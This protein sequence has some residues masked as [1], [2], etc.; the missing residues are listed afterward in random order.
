MQRVLRYPIRSLFSI[1]FLA[2]FLLTSGFAV[3]RS[4]PVNCVSWYDGCNTC[5]C[6]NGKITA[7]TK[8]FCVRKEKPRCLKRRPC[9]SCKQMRC[10]AGTVCRMVNGCGR[11][12]PRVV[13][14]RCPKN[15][16]VWY[17]GCN[18]CKCR[19][20]KITGCTK[21]LCKKHG[22]PYCKRKN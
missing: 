4:C 1:L 6:V 7:C 18:T 8:R 9:A 17:D 14:H 20:G 12:V 10:R 19:K 21:R 13:R 22:R 2:G 15:C 5:R 16:S 3:A 11:C